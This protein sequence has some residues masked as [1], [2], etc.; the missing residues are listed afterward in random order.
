MFCGPPPPPAV[1]RVV[2]VL[3]PAPLRERAVV[4]PEPARGLEALPVPA[5]FPAPTD[6]ADAA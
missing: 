1:R 6:V 3:D 2:G 4:E 5:D